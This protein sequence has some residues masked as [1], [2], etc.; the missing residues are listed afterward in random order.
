[1]S[2]QRLQ[3]LLTARRTRRSSV[4]VSSRFLRLP[5]EFCPPSVILL[6]GFLEIIR[7]ALIFV[8]ARKP[9]ASMVRSVVRSDSVEASPRSGTSVRARAQR[10]HVFRTTHDHATHSMARAARQHDLQ[11][12]ISVEDVVL[13]LRGSAAWPAVER[14]LVRV[15][16]EPRHFVRA[17]KADPQAM[18]TVDGDLIWAHAGIWH[19]VV[20]QFRRASVDADHRVAKPIRD[21]HVGAIQIRPGP[22]RRLFAANAWLRNGFR[23]VAGFQILGQR[24]CG[25]WNFHDLVG[26]AVEVLNHIVLDTTPP[27][28]A[29]TITGDTVGGR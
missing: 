25:Q 23:D 8:K 10:L 20:P 7:A 17:L 12:T 26:L 16:I 4:C 14:P 27:R 28:I 11:D 18:V 9:H 15:R 19:W 29:L 21:P 3:S 24:L 13:P 2:E 22:S 1:M 6:R 5:R